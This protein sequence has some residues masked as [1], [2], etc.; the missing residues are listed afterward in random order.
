MGVLDMYDITQ[1]MDLNDE[2]RAFLEFY[3]KLPEPLQK[4]VVEFMDDD[5]AVRAR[6][7]VILDDVFGELKDGKGTIEEI[8]ARKLPQ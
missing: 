4:V 8:V 1:Y 5:P 6:A 2:E 3:K 7:K